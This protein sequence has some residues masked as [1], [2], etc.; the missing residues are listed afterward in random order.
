MGVDADAL[1]YTCRDCL[2]QAHPELQQQNRNHGAT[3]RGADGVDARGTE[4]N[5]GTATEQ[6]SNQFDNG[7]TQKHWYLLENLY[8]VDVMVDDPKLESAL[9]FLEDEN[10][11]AINTFKRYVED[12]GNKKNFHPLAILSVMGLGG[13]VSPRHL[14]K[15]EEYKRSKWIT[16]SDVRATNEMLKK[17]VIRRYELLKNL[18]EGSNNDSDQSSTGRKKKK[19]GGGGAASKVNQ[20]TGPKYLCGEIMYKGLNLKL[21]EPEIHFVNSQIGVFLD[22]LEATKSKEEQEKLERGDSISSST[23]LKMRIIDAVYFEAFCKQLLEI[24]RS[25]NRMELDRHNSEDRPPNIWELSA[26]QCNKR[27]WS[28]ISSRTNIHRLLNASIELVVENQAEVTPEYVEE[29]YKDLRSHFKKAHQ[30]WKK[31]GNGKDNLK[32]NGEHAHL[33]EEI[34]NGSGFFWFWVLRISG[35]FP[36]PSAAS[37]F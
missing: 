29:T 5:R 2:P 13:E 23:I 36:E 26:H 1:K 15:I 14:E 18:D 28:P 22:H 12:D 4:T 9:L 3:D 24:D 21:Y 16:S 37:F 7:G 35:K 10:S 17:E 6:D 34:S 33:I 19:S 25:M 31:S 8:Q 27:D 30:G 32:D 11:S 20:N